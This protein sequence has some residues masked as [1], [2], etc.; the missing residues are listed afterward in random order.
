MSI[1]EVTEKIRG[2]RCDLVE[3]TGGEPLLQEGVYPLTEA[4]L[5]AGATVMIE[6]SG[7]G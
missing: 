5:E 2:Y 4:M 7:G 6:T 3:V 1:S